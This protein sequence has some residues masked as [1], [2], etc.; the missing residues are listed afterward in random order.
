MQCFILYLTFFWVHLHTWLAICNKLL[1]FWSFVG[2]QVSNTWWFVFQITGYSSLGQSLP[3]S[4]RFLY[5]CAA[6]LRWLSAPLPPKHTHISI[7]FVFLARVFG[8]LISSF[9]FPSEFQC[10]LWF[11]LFP[12][13]QKG[14]DT[15]Y[16]SLPLLSVDCGEQTRR[17]RH[18]YNTPKLYPC[19]PQYS[20]SSHMVSNQICPGS[21]CII[22]PVIFGSEASWW[23][24]GP[25]LQR[26]WKCR[27]MK[28][29]QWL[30]G[31][32]W[33]QVTVPPWGPRVHGRV[34]KI[35]SCFMLH[36]HLA[37]L[38]PTSPAQQAPTCGK[39]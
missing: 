6:L 24:E 22:S 28:L 23:H 37:A 3:K 5:Y 18:C 4:L 13:G 25:S 29:S 2:F 33:H 14:S 7:F 10:T 31:H 1:G 36:P 21:K 17:H 32:E 11:C 34:P 9:K 38:L 19:T 30:L 35:L 39:Q 12:S 16:T 15:T 8:R 27:D 26:V 20:E